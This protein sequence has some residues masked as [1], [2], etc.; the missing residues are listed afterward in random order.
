ML[1]ESINIRL[2]DRK[3]AVEV[4]FTFKNHGKATR[5]TMGFPEEG[6]A[7]GNRSMKGFRSW[8]DGVPAKVKR[9]R[10]TPT[11]GEEASWKAVY[12][13]EVPFRRGQTRRVRVTYTGIYGG[14]VTGRAMLEYVLRTGKTWKGPIGQCRITVDWTQLKK[15]A[16]PELDVPD[17]DPKWRQIG[18]T[19][20]QTLIRNLRP[21]T[22]LIINLVPGFW[23]FW[24]NGE[25][26]PYL[27]YTM[28]QMIR[29]HLTDPLI[30]TAS[31]SSF[32]G[33]Y[34]DEERWA[35][36]KRL[37]LGKGEEVKIEQDTVVQSG[38]KLHKLR[39]PSKLMPHSWGRLGSEPYVYLRD[40]L[41][42][43][44]GNYAYDSS[45]KRARLYLPK[46]RKR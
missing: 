7:G 9:R 14:D 20:S 21:Q 28:P 29:G 27:G 45:R 12:L 2:K 15:Y 25:R 22:D 33:D 6:S 3:A 23:N 40:F 46:H 35:P 43:Y 39:R 24:I 18:R 41:Q 4:L 42:A 5:V 8:I 44:G 13:K 30:S 11:R 36:W 16:A 38:K 19:R 10:L 1:A 17:V 32:F 34:D 31:L 37:G 26:V